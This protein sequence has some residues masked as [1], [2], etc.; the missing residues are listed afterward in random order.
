MNKNQNILNGPITEDVLKE[1]H[2]LEKVDRVPHEQETTDFKRKARLLQSLW[3]EEQGLPIGSQPMRSQEGKP[4]RP[5]GSRIDLESARETGA[6]FLSQGVRSAVA[7][8]LENPQPHQTL[9]ENRLYCD[10]LSSM[11][12][13]FNL[14]GELAIDTDLADEAVHTW[15]PDTPGTVKD[16][17]FE[18]SPGRSQKGEYLENRSAFDV[19]FILDLGNGKKGV[20]GVETKYH[21]HAVPMAP[22]ND[23]RME[24]Y[25]TVGEQSGVFAEG[26]L[27]E[28]IGTELQQIWLD[29]LLALSMLQHPSGEWEWAR[30]IL[31]YPSR[32]PSFAR[33]SS[34]YQKLLKEQET[35]GVS[36][37]EEL[38][39]GGVL[40]SELETKFRER[41]L[42]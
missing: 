9:D 31:V 41:Y 17:R 3:R 19:A 24:R 35:F 21:E 10:L 25:K 37:I 30:F 18:W 2:C 4:V 12:M 40:P 29:H 20:I 42:W 11:P 14:F 15:W 38:L 7:K 8:R 36:T 26:A 23:T 34:Q 39:D 27:E 1:H 6:N 33:V 32:N 13:C 16:V 22:A 5:L 28:I